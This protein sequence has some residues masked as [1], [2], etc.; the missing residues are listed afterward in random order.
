MKLSAQTGRWMTKMLEYG[1]A[2]GGMGTN[3]VTQLQFHIYFCGKHLDMYIDE[4]ITTTV[5][6]C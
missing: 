6:V 4:E 5:F 2:V 3:T 1:P